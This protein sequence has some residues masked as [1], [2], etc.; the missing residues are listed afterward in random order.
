M[1]TESH[2]GLKILKVGQ[3]GP[4]LQ[5]RA[6]DVLGSLSGQPGNRPKHHRWPIKRPGHL[7]ETGVNPRKEK[8]RSDEN[9][10]RGKSGEVGGGRGLGELET[11][12]IG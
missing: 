1:T 2:T 4:S 9:V 7:G 12:L 5:G 10:L 8:K 3:S 11:T 6:R